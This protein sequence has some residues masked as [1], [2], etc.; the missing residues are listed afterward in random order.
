MTEARIVVAAHRSRCTSAQ[1]PGGFPV[2]AG[3]RH[4]LALAACVIGLASALSSGSAAA[5]TSPALARDPTSVANPKAT[6]AVV[7]G[8]VIPAS[9]YQRA[10]Q[11]A[12]R[13]K[14]Y[15]AKPPDADLAKLRRDVGDDVVNRVLLLREAERRG[16]LPDTAAIQAQVAA[17]DKQYGAS[18]NWKTNRAQMLSV[19]VPQLE[20]DSRLER[21]AALVRQVGEP[22]DAELGSYYE[23]HR[24][25]FVEPERLK[26]S[27]ILLKV[28]PSASQAVWDA[29][30]AEA[31]DVH[32]RLVAGADFAEMARLHSGDVSAA[33][34]GAL[35]Y[36][37]RGMLPEAVHKLVDGLTPGAFGEPVQLLEGVTI[38]RLD[39]RRAAVQRRLD[40]VKSRC[41]E[42]WKRD[43]SQA[44]WLN[45]IAELRR[46][47]TI[48]I[49]ES[50]YG[51]WPSPGAPAG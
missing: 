26:L 14:Y 37:H 45:L 19:V 42:L 8:A 35:E 7:D 9:D 10:L 28:D 11:V 5:Q 36:T 32:R 44:Q 49:D 18:A 39:D 31:R 43:A 40:E 15:H 25:L 50:H 24:D 21:L 27:V 22:S 13:N 51:A 30:L 41:A 16:I 6:F 4:V 47:A 29:A 20:G 2:A 38:L 12:V 46:R 34:G 23:S 17:Y 3:V 33:A 48:H 1:L